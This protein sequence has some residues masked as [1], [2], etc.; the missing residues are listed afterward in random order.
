MNDLSVDSPGRTEE[1]NYSQEDPFYVIGLS[2]EAITEIEDYLA[3]LTPDQWLHHQTDYGDQKNFRLCDIHCPIADS[4]VAEIGGS[5]FETINKKYEFDIELYE[6]QILKYGPGGNF[7]WH[8]D[9]GIAPNKKVWRKLSLSVQLSDPKDYEGGELIIVD[10]VN[11]HCQIPK[12]KG[13]SI[14]F[15]SRCPHKAEPVTKGERLVLV[16]WASGP[17]LR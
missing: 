9:Y 8:C 16:G 11:R 17:K 1:F 7:N 14:V 4:V 12:S 13:A 6:F 5:I 10:Y 3:T 15:D 2:D